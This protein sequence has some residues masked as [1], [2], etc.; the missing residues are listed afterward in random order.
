[1]GWCNV[2]SRSGA[3][4][5]LSAEHERRDGG[6]QHRIAG[7][8]ACAGR[9]NAPAQPSAQTGM[10]ARPWVHSPR[11]PCPSCGGASAHTPT[12]RAEARG[13]RAVAG[14]RR[15]ERE[16]DGS[17]GGGD[18]GE[19]DGETGGGE[20]TRGAPQHAPTQCARRGRRTSDAAGEVPGTGTIGVGAGGLSRTIN[21][22]CGLTSAASAGAFTPAAPAGSSSRTNRRRRRHRTTDTTGGEST[23]LAPSAP[24]GRTARST[25]HAVSILQA[26]AHRYTSRHR[27]PSSGA[28]APFTTSRPERDAARAR[29]GVRGRPARTQCGVKVG[30]GSSTAPARGRGAAPPRGPRA[31]QPGE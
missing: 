6:L 16:G 17:A 21:H 29:A 7:V 26:R 27:R 3:R 28:T 24:A 9:C 13:A 8:A 1:M 4:T 31:H 23:A 2:Q 25:N 10:G 30:R 15:A 18:A 22:S 14:P 11:G 19:D 12:R 20:C 5:A